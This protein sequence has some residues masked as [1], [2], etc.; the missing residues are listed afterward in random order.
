M[1]FSCTTALWEALA[2]DVPKGLT[3]GR[4]QKDSVEG[5]VSEQ[6]GPARQDGTQKSG[7]GWSKQ[8]QFLFGG[9]ISTQRTKFVCCRNYFRT[10]LTHIF[11]PTLRN[12]AAG[13]L[14]SHL[15]QSTTSPK[16][17]TTRRWVSAARGASE[18]S[19]PKKGQRASVNEPAE[20]HHVKRICFIR[21]RAHNN[22]LSRGFVCRLLINAVTT[23]QLTTSA[24][25]WR[26]FYKKARCSQFLIGVLD[27]GHVRGQRCSVCDRFW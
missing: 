27:C 3:L 16:K 15:T 21:L 17:N 5:T 14:L 9:T 4:T 8:W 24:A 10:A 19:C 23:Q 12:Q 1:T 13:V 11:R 6:S 26:W 7:S 25:Q 18:G 2:R 20:F 22:A